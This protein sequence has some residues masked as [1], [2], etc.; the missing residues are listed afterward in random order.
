MK[1]HSSGILTVVLAA[2]QSSRMGSPKPLLTVGGISFL[3]RIVNLHKGLGLE[4]CVVLGEHREA[5]Q[6]SVDLSGVSVVINRQ[7]ELGQLSSIQL[8]VAHAEGRNA[9]I[10][11]PVDHPLVSPETLEALLAAHA[12]APDRI[13]TPEC[14]GKTGHPT[15]FPSHFFSDLLTAPLDQGARYVIAE[16]HSAVRRVTVK[17]EGILKNIDTPEDYRRWVGPTDN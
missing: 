6:R 7:P 1:P 16:R 8:G 2:G 12:K 14:N 4:V 15:L 5:I 13:L 17:D 11:H 9:I 3:K 10:V